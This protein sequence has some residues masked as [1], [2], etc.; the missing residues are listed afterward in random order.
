MIVN[1]FYSPNL[2]KVLHQDLDPYIFNTQL[3]YH[4]CYAYK[5]AVLNR[6]K[7]K[8]P[9]DLDFSVN[10][11]K[12]KEDFLIT[13]NNNTAE[14][15][16]N[17]CVIVN[18]Q[19]SFTVDK[20][21]FIFQIKLKTSFYTKEKCFMEMNHP[22]HLDVNL[23]LIKGKYDIS[24]WLRPINAAFEVQKLP[25][26]IVLSRESILC[27]LI[28]HANKINEPIK[29]KENT[30]PSY[31]LIELAEGNAQISSYVKSAKTLIEKGAQLL[32]RYI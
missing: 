12:D 23:K 21:K 24:Q 17:E 32:K 11:N 5:W 2:P 18:P 19:K 8:C 3:G 27:E 6:F 26:R 1:Y 31:D 14:R 22:E 9:Y 29:L 7:V 20:N 15:S 25:C 13:F 4:K 10:Y 16:F 28:F 30:N